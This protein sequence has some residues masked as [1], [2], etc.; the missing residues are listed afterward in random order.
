M[1]EQEEEPCSCS[2]SDMLYLQR[3]FL[4]PLVYTLTSRKIAC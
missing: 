3:C 1:Q 4:R 2:H